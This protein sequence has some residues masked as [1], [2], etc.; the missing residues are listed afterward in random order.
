MTTHR[1]NSDTLLAGY[2]RAKTLYE[3]VFDLDKLALNTTLVPYWLGD[4]CFW[5]R[6]KTWQGSE[7]RL[8]HAKAGS[9]QTAFDHQALATALG[10]LVGEP[11]KADNLP[12]SKV[13]INLQPLTIQFEAFDK[14]YRFDAEAQRCDIVEPVAS[15][16]EGSND[17]DSPFL[18]TDMFEMPNK[19]LAGD[20][21]ISP[22]GKKGVFVREYNLWLEDLE[23]GEVR[24]LTTDG[25]ALFPYA[26]TP[27]AMGYAPNAEIQALWS[28]DSKNLL[29]IQTDNRQVKTTPLVH[30]V[31]LDGSLRPKVTSYRHALP[32]D[33]HWEE[34]SLL[35]ITIDSGKIQ[36]ANYK[37]ISVEP[38]NT[39][40]PFV[41]AKQ[42]WWHTGSRLA[43]FIDV[44]KGAQ[45]VR[46]IEFDIGTGNT[47]CLFE[48]TSKTYIK[49]ASHGLPVGI[50]LLPLPDS[51]ELIWFSE[52][53]DWGHLYL[54]DLKTGVLKHPITEGKWVVR[55]ILHFDAKQRELWIQTSGRVENYDPLY[56]DICRVNI[57][58][59][60]LTTVV[61]EDEEYWVLAPGTIAHYMARYYD[62]DRFINAHAL[63]PNANYL[64]A[65][66][67][68]A[69]QAPVSILLNRDGETILE[70][71]TADVSALPDNWHWPEPVKMLAADKKTAIY[72]VI[73]KP[74][75]FSPD[76]HYPIIDFSPYSPDLNCAPKGAFRNNP[77]GGFFYPQAAALAELGFIVVAIDG[78]GSPCRDRAFS[79]ANHGRMDASNYTED[80]IAGIQQ[81]A[82]Q[83]PYMDLNQIG[84]L[85]LGTN[86]LE[87]LQ[88]PEFYKVGVYFK[89]SDV[90]LTGASLADYREGQDFIQNHFEPV[91]QLAKNLQGKLLLIQHLSERIAA[92][93]GALRI[94]EALQQS[95]KDFDLLL[96]PNSLPERYVFRRIVDYFVTHL[97]GVE[98][99]KE[100]SFDSNE[101]D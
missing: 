16:E 98:P 96:F 69:D 26:T 77:D 65:N 79:H 46:V 62:P 88:Y 59:G 78:R 42:A 73:F 60:E 21:L 100:F 89:L 94:V 32:G 52:R 29:T 9:N 44:Q 81:L 15:E 91:E 49:L 87:L 17:D 74:A 68:R 95:N 12:I 90:R 20:Q 97:Q 71:E 58:T 83:R 7:F 82:A 75:D 3:G 67:S 53:S 55:N 35:S 51:Q 23:S 14:H 56:Q 41:G 28:P 11:I 5:Y 31:P 27:I 72:G 39:H 4:D 50:V 13:S 10:N 30:H 93:A 2:E 64:V 36:R 63:S 101:I 18:A 6:R 1:H 76:K 8:V 54:Y 34:Y 40:G 47:R 24:A 19:P 57:D 66:R 48:E 25:E 61:A 99:P 38:N 92:P 84:I 43:Y 45:I 33:E 70:L 22:D 80:R 37:K 85:G 86:G